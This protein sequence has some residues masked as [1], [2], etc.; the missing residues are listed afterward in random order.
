MLADLG[1]GAPGA[2]KTQPGRVWLGIRFGADF[3]HV[4]VFQ[5]GA[6]WFGFVV[7]ARRHHPFANPAVDG[8]GKVHHRGTA[9]QRQDLSFGGEDIDRVR[10]QITFDMVPEFGRVAGLVLDVEQRLQPLG[11]QALVGCRLGVAAF[12][13][14]V[15][16]NPRLGHQVHGIGAQLELHVQAGRPHQRGVQRLVAVDFGNRDVVLELAGYGLVQL[17]QQ[18]HGGVAGDGVLHDHPEAINIG[19][20]RKAQVL[21]VHL[22][23]DGI[24]RFLPPGNAH[25]HARALEYGLHLALHFVHQVAAAAAGACDRLADDRVPP[26]Q[27][28]AETQFFEFAVGFVQA[29]AVGDGRINVQR[30]LC[31]PLP[32]GARHLGHGA[33]IVGTVGQLDQDHPHIARHGQQHF[34]EGLGLGFFPAVELQAVQLGQPVHQF[35]HGRAEA[36]DQLRFADAAIFHGVVQ[37]G[38][39]QCLGVQIPIGALGGHGN[40][41]GDVGGAVFA[42]LPQVGF[43]SKTVSQPHLLQVAGR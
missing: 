1:A 29:Q 16:G 36:F 13:Q 6:Q 14:P 39:H 27:Q 37:Q 17:V 23:V 41:M 40:R 11:S 43:V 3:H 25:F 30:L 15:R 7:D 18:A 26:G 4:A 9:R 35:S 32:F 33:H 28:V 8:V 24:E 21:V 5:L 42:Q 12:V 2:D 31:N 38:R 34:A 10:E 20:L 22:A 19:H